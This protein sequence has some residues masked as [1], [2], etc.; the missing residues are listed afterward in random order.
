MLKPS[1]KKSKHRNRKALDKN[2]Q[3]LDKQTMAVITTIGIIVASIIKI[4]MIQSK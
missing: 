2:Y 4:M 3:V 1:R